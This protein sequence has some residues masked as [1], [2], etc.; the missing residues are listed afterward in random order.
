MQTIEGA[1]WFDFW[2]KGRGGLLLAAFGL[3]AIPLYV[4][5]ALGRSGGLDANSPPAVVL[6]FVFTLVIGFCAA[7]AA[8]VPTASLV[9][10]YLRP[11]STARLVLCQLL[12]IMIS[13]AANYLLT[14]WLLNLGGANWPLVGPACFLATTAACA[15]MCIWAFEGSVFAQMM[16]C[17]SVLFP[18]SVWFSRCY[19]ARTFGNW[20]RMWRDPSAP[21]ILT[22]LALCVL[23]YVVSVVSV[24]RTRR[25]DLL[26]F[27]AI[28]D[29]FER[30][31]SNWH[32]TPQR[33]RS[34][35]AAQLWREWHQKM[36][37]ASPFMIAVLGVFLMSLA[38]LR[39]F[40]T[41]EF[42]AVAF[43]LPLG[44]QVYVFPWAFGLVLGNCGTV[45][46][47]D[48]MSHCLATRPISDGQLA[49]VL[50][51][52][53]G[54]VVVSTWLVWLVCVALS[55]GLVYLMGE[56]DAI[57]QVLH[58]PQ[59]AWQI[60]ISLAL[61]GLVSAWSVLAGMSA[62]V[63][64]G[65]PRIWLTALCS[66]FGL[67]IL[68]LVVGSHL[69]GH[70]FAALNH[71]VAIAAGLVLALLTIATFGVARWRKLLEARFAAMVLTAAL[72][73]AALIILFWPLELPHTSTKILT[74]GALS[75]AFFPLAAMPLA[76]HWNRH[77]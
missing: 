66:C 58:A 26:S 59:K 17:C 22:L 5:D 51:A 12:F 75:L 32:F 45:Q 57:V 60:T 53:C 4:Y 65:H 72:G 15:V 1:L 29:W 62:L 76:I 64:T 28:A 31:F 63:A 61:A 55:A 16:A 10:H 37:A 41:G 35:F 71:A 39:R 69:P 43:M 34:P 49:R 27:Q 70:I 19:G 46:R 24:T 40:E 3:T 68:Y 50:L 25:G 8:L 21:E 7:T 42:L 13:V 67:L 6:H 73:C 54:L 11:V 20:N 47:Y 9:R 23:A 30:Q 14:A 33:F 44:L 48:G 36:G 2:R 74:I 56:G 38:L 52:N 77:R 18:L